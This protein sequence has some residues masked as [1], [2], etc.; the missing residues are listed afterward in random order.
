MSSL[1]SELTK[2]LIPRLLLK[3][4]KNEKHSENCG[5]ELFSNPRS[6]IEQCSTCRTTIKTGGRG[7][8]FAVWSHTWGLVGGDVLQN[9]DQHSV[10]LFGDNFFYACKMAESLVSPARSSA[11]VENRHSFAMLLFLPAMLRQSHFDQGFTI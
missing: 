9:F 8:I 10:C 7:S 3:L 4:G 2:R 11:L 6:L 5:L 1:S